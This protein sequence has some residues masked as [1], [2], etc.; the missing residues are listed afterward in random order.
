LLKGQ[1][2][3]VQLS[4][5]WHKLEK[6]KMLPSF[7]IGYNNTSV[8]GWQATGQNTEKYFSGSRRFSSVS[9]GIG[10]PIFS[11]AQRSRINAADV[12]IRQRKQE[13]EV[14]HQQLNAN[15]QDGIKIYFHNGHLVESYR[16]TMLPNASL[17]IAV[18][19]NK[20][21]AGE[22]G[23]LNWVILI[24]QAIQIRGEYLNTVQELNEAAIEI[25]R[26]TATN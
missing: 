2:Q 4:E 8:I 7:N 11:R 24:N 9:A 18:A 12:L 21:N 5:Q 3:Q 10:I 13:L 14:M 25:E 1:Q 19:T 23:Y 16:A 6:S 15:L 17:T 20:L 26:I 22:I